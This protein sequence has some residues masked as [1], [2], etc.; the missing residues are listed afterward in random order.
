MP[1]GMA[2]QNPLGAF[3]IPCPSASMVFRRQFHLLC[4]DLPRCKNRLTVGED[5]V[6]I[7]QFSE[8]VNSLTC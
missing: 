3:F 7:G 2:E 4:F 8:N 5:T 6:I 1:E